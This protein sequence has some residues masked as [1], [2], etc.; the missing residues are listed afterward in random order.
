ML[1]LASA[2]SA[3]VQCRLGE[4]CSLPFDAGLALSSTGG[5]TA[6]PVSPTTPP[7]ALACVPLPARVKPGNVFG[8]ACGQ[9]PAGDHF[10]RFEGG[11][12]SKR[13]D[14]RGDPARALLHVDSWGGATGITLSSGGSGYYQ[15]S[16][17]AYV[18]QP[19]TMPSRSCS[20]RVT[21]GNDQDGSGAPVTGIVM[22]NRGDNFT[23]VAVLQ[24][25]SIVTQ[26]PL[27][28]T[29]RW[30]Q[31]SPFRIFWIRET[32]ED[33]YDLDDFV[34]DMSSWP[35]LGC[36]NNGQCKALA[37]GDVAIPHVGD[38]KHLQ[39]W[40]GSD[41]FT[42]YYNNVFCYATRPNL[43]TATHDQCVVRTELDVSYKGGE[44]HMLYWVRGSQRELLALEV[45]SFDTIMA[46]SALHEEG[47]RLAALFPKLE[48]AYNRGELVLM[49]GG[50]APS[51]DVPLEVSDAVGS[52][53]ATLARMAAAWSPGSDV[54]KEIQ[55]LAVDGA[56]L[57][58]SA[59]TRGADG[60]WAHVPTYL[61]EGG[62]K[63]DAALKLLYT[64]GSAS[65]GTQS[66]KRPNPAGIVAAKHGFCRHVKR[67]VT[68]D[69]EVPASER[70]ACWAGEADLRGG[71][72]HL[73]RQVAPS[74]TDIYL[75]ALPTRA[76]DGGP[77]FGFDVCGG[78][79]SRA[80]KE[81]A[82]LDADASIGRVVR[83]AEEPEVAGDELRVPVAGPVGG[84][85]TFPADTI[86]ATV[87]NRRG[88]AVSQPIVGTTTL[89]SPPPPPPP[90]DSTVQETAASLKK[91]AVVVLRARLAALGLP[92]KGKKQEL[93]VKL[94][95]YY[96]GSSWPIVDTSPPP[97]PP[98]PRFLMQVADVTRYTAGGQSPSASV[99][100]HGP[101]DAALSVRYD[102]LRLAAGAIRETDPR[103]LLGAATLQGVT[104]CP[105]ARSDG[106]HPCRVRAR[107]GST[108]RFYVEL[109]VQP[110]DVALRQPV[111]RAAWRVDVAVETVGRGNNKQTRHGAPSRSV[112]ARVL[113]LES[114]AGCGTG[115]ARIC[116]EEVEVEAVTPR[117]EA[118][119]MVGRCTMQCPDHPNDEPVAG[120]ALTAFEACNHSVSRPL[121][122]HPLL[123]QVRMGARRGH[124][125]PPCGLL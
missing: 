121:N 54:L 8:L 95:E 111:A 105:S 63:V 70:H 11:T 38:H 40:W 106:L 69:S 100:C 116:G 15:R 52:A 23:V 107:I 45:A 92:E 22:D 74:D 96:D 30:P 99:E 89:P 115:S 64:V 110:D 36:G 19:P 24:G 17:R 27:P 51:R 43:A 88:P 79:P 61:A 75:R 12:K 1:L 42:A 117:D 29:P 10:I 20:L 3:T 71:R 124:Q 35:E 56:R 68:Y 78:H 62:A 108:A 101:D 50:A 58:T 90:T 113:L 98:P 37:A 65:D 97:P 123:S 16:A 118:N 5:I 34:L 103:M 85:A 26:P 46:L 91:R 73:A 66:G 21:V 80:G 125:A 86:V 84:D 114:C 18:D 13:G 59:A 55:Q 57:H 72:F 104:G 47:A 93:L 31:P 87:L 39:A 119:S 14:H 109:D 112:N 44:A 32:G 81:L 76:A 25:R 49:S 4:P 60:S 48:H 83:I 53:A 120:Y 77:L 33:V 41:K 82:L 28:L 7:D 2:A 67:V 122:T 94:G 9:Y 6:H 102:D